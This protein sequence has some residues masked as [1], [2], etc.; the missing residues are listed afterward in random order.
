MMSFSWLEMTELAFVSQQGLFCVTL[1]RQGARKAVYLANQ[2]MTPYP[3]RALNLKRYRRP[4]TCTR[5]TLGEE[6]RIISKTRIPKTQN[7]TGL[8]LEL[9]SVSLP[10]TGTQNIFVVL[11]IYFRFL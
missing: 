6:E 5:K 9:A 2:I 8:P 11:G 10:M 4:A 7:Q 1:I 3:K